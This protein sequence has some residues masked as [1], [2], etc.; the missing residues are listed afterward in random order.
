M[1]AWDRFLSERDREHT[2]RFWGKQKA[3]GLGTKPALLVIDNIYSILG[4]RQDLLDAAGVVPASCGLEGWDAIDRTVDLIAAAREHGVPVIYAKLRYD[5]GQSV[6]FGRGV[7]PAPAFEKLPDWMVERWPEI[8]EEIA[9]QPG[10]VVI[11]KHSA[12]MFA[13]TPLWAH[14]TAIGADTVICC[15]NSTSGCVRATVVDAGACKL[16]VGVVEECTFD[17]T[18]AS[19][20]MSLYD[21]HQKYADVMS[22]DET[23]AYFASVAAKEAVPA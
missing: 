1:R 13:G 23:V 12:S 19:H 22:L 10:D 6:V 18:E 17:R 7:R 14:L 5:I 21:M 9:P 4:P 20:A 16:K 2:E 11:E 8:V 15:G 3:F